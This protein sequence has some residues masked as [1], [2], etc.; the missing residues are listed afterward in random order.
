MANQ[1][2]LSV[3]CRDF[4]E[5]QILNRLDMFLATI[6]YSASRPG[7]DR[8]T[9]RAIDAAEP[10]VLEQDYRSLPLEIAGAIG[11]VGGYIH[12]DCSYEFHCHWDLALFDPENAKFTVEPQPLEILCHGQDYDNQTWRDDGHFQACLG[13]EHFFTGHAGLLGSRA[14][15]GEPAA[16]R[17]EA[18]FLEAMAWP[19][20]IE[21]YHEK[22]R[23]NIR[24]LLDWTHRIATAVPLERL[25]LW[26]EG[27]ED[28]EARLED[29]LAVR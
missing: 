23:E 16:S 20:N 3:W 10:P 12:S 17:E 5:D 15:A 8:I 6:P 27:E 14:R 4:P 28:F 19:E 29:I 25:R 11:I 9:V 24:K 7:I 18:R 26:S 21:R 1:A 2:F 13:F 22:T